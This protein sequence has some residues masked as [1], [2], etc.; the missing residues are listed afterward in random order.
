[1][2]LLWVS[3]RHTR[4]T[5]RVRL[6]K[7]NCG[8]DAWAVSETTTFAQA[9][10]TSLAAHPALAEAVIKAVLPS[11]TESFI[12]SRTLLQRIAAAG[13]VSCKPK[14]CCF[15]CCQCCT[16]RLL[17][18]GILLHELCAMT[19]VSF[20]RDGLLSRAYP[21]V[22]LPHAHAGFVLCG[23]QQGRS[24]YLPRVASV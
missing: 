11:Q 7:L 21:P 15:A 4:L 14:Q 12:A 13:Y 2:G 3:Q 23:N 16:S 22:W 9:T 8:P 6:L 10:R 18:C 17:A 24:L 20:V 5:N 1:M 19:C